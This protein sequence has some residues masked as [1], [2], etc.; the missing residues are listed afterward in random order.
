MRLRLG[1]TR[2]SG[3]LLLQARYLRAR[4]LRLLW[5]LRLLVRGKRSRLLRV[6]RMRLCP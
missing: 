5:W 1:G 2:R 3:L 6:G 4:W